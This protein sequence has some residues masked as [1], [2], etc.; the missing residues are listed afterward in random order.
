M[1]DLDS[2]DHVT[3]ASLTW[4]MI[5][6]AGDVMYG[7]HG[8]WRFGYG[9]WYVEGTWL[10]SYNMMQHVVCTWRDGYVIRVNAGESGEGNGGIMMC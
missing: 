7:V 2:S 10:E 6:D 9:V 8:T 5:T 3:H 1:L 4:V